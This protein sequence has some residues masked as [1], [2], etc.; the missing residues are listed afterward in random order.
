MHPLWPKIESCY[1]QLWRAVC[2]YERGH[3]AREDLIQ[4]VLMALWQAL[5]KLREADKWL[6][7]ALRVAHNI[8]ACH[9]RQAMRGPRSQSFEEMPIELAHEEADPRSEWLFN[10]L[11]H[12][13]VALRQPL[14]LQLEG[15]DYQEI[16]A[17][18]GI[19]ADNVG[20]RVHRAR[21]RLKQTM[22][23]EK[24]DVE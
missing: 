13:P 1:P 4:E 5:P 22:Q 24:A 14:M 17:I 16:A 18:L 2:G 10:A 12:L 6:P 21:A 7:F 23:E 9:V 8:G 19:S 15:F 3:Q 20:V 11:T